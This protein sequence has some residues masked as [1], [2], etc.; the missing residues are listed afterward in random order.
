MLRALLPVVLFSVIVGIWGE[1]WAKRERE[2]R[3]ARRG[4]KGRP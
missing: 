2:E 1:Y 4:S 3:R